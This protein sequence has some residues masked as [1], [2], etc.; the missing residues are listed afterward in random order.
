M[1]KRNPPTAPR[2]TRTPAWDQAHGTYLAGRAHLDGVDALVIEMSNKWGFG[3]LR[4]LVDAPWREKFDR[5][6]YLMQQAVEG[7]DLA[8]IQEQAAR[9]ISAWRKLDALATEANAPQA[10]PEVWEAVLPDG[11]VMA[12]VR[13]PGD[14]RAL[15]PRGRRV[16]VYTLDEIAMIL[17]DYKRV[18]EIKIQW[19][20]ASVSV[21]RRSVQDPLNSIQTPVGLDAELNDSIPF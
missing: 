8:Q 5:Q 15:D 4:L 11:T 9:T 2:V 19:P 16:A 13:D 12:I 6:R 7:G 18:N 17:A 3:R 1:P 21:I 14:A 20:G 10:S